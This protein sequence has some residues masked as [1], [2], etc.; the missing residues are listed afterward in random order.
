M[1]FKELKS[2]PKDEL[3]K[4]RDEL[5]KE[6]MKEHTQI[7]TGTVPKSPGKLR[8]LKKTIARITMLLEGKT[9]A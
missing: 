9:K 1:K 6:L 2:L 7:S 8:T 4:K 3:V 5:Q